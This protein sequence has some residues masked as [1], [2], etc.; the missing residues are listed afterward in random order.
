VEPKTLTSSQKAMEVGRERLNFL[1]WVG[2][3]NQFIL[4][5]GHKRWGISLGWGKKLN[6]SMCWT[7]DM[8]YGVGL[9]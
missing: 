3:R 7:Q 2:S 4:C 6:Y 9:G 5:A 8:G 1:A